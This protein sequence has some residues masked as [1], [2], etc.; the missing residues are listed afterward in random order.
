MYIRVSFLFWVSMVL[1]DCAMSECL[2]VIMQLAEKQ[3]DIE[4]QDGRE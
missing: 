2:W 4:R 3:I 1:A